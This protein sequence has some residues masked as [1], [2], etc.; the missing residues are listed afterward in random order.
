MGLRVRRSVK[1]W[2]MWSGTRHSRDLGMR[3]MRSMYAE[4]TTLMIVSE[5]MNVTTWPAVRMSWTQ[6]RAVR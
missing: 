1:R 6:T 5:F 4:S 2:R 3:G